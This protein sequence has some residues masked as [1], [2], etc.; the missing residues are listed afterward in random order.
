MKQSASVNKTVKTL[1]I[2]A[3]AIMMLVPFHALVTVWVS[4]W[5]GHYTLLRLWK[6]L[7]LL[8]ITSGALF[9]V[10]FK[11][12]KIGRAL[13]RSWIFRLILAYSL[14]LVVCGLFAKINQD[15]TTKSLWYGLL[16]D[17]R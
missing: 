1:S 2:L 17:L 5:A 11:D 9:L 6:E 7:L 3:A 8:A 10:L 16:V 13:A 12:R 14:V 15:V 4:S